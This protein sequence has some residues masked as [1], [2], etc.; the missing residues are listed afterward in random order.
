M[1]LRDPSNM[2]V[3]L[4]MTVLDGGF[5]RAEYAV[6]LFNVAIQAG[7]AAAVRD[8]PLA[9]MLRY[10]LYTEVSRLKQEIQAKAVLIIMIAGESCPLAWKGGKR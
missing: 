6:F 7:Y 9:H 2:A 8:F 5:P 3:M 1:L 10:S 4:I